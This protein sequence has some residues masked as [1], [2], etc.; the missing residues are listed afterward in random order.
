MDRRHVAVL[1]LALLLVV[2]GCSGLLSGDATPADGGE[3]TSTATPAPATPTPVPFTYPDGYS[4][5][6]VT[7]S[8]AA[9]GAH[10]DGI[11][12][13]DSFTVSYR[14]AVQTP[15]RSVQVDFTQ[16]VNTVERRAHLVSAVTGGT[17]IAQYYANDTVYVR[18]ESPSTNQTSY[19]SRQQTL[20]LE[21]FTGTQFVAPAVANA[22][23]GEAAVVERDGETLVRYE[24]RE[25]TNATGLLGSDTST[26]NVTSFSA[27]LLV[28]EDGV[29]RRVEYRA[30]VDRPGGERTLEVVVEVSELDSTTVQRPDWVNRAAS[31]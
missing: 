8:E 16:Q 30:T 4:E 7:D 22:S 26:E 29:V 5:T 31:S 21:E 24:A 3:A 13:H 6:G 11:L 25:L 19:T 17:N 2:S 20:N 10:T 27:T 15:N 12:S 9:A 18:S 23:Y 28:D 14:A 1:S